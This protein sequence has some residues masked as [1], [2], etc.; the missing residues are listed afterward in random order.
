[1]FLKKTS[2]R[3][4]LKIAVFH[5]AFVYSGGGERIVIE[6]VLGLAAK[7]HK[8]DLF[9][10]AI[11][12]E[13]CYPELLKRVGPRS[14]I[15]QLPKGFPLRDGLSMLV[16]SLLV[17][18]LAPFFSGYDV[19]V[20]ANQPGS[21]LAF[22]LSKILRKP[23]IVYLNQPNRMIY[24]REIDRETGWTTNKSFLVLQKLIALFKPLV[25]WLDRLSI[26]KSNYLLA[27]GQYIG[28]I[29]SKIYGKDFVDCPAGANPFELTDIKLEEKT[30]YEGNFN[31]AGHELKK[32]YIL[33][34]N[35]HYPQKKFEYALEALRFV[36]K[37]CPEASLAISGAY[38]DY[39]DKLKK[40]VE[41]YHLE[42]NVTFLGEVKEKDLPVLY[43][44]AAVYVYTSPAEDYGMGVVEAQYAAVPV[45]AWNHAGPTVT[46][47]NGLTGFLIEPYDIKDYAKKIYYLLE[48]KESRLQMGRAAREHVLQKFTW[49]AHI[50]TL[51]G[52]IFKSLNI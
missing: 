14:L 15:P 43:Q 27:N 36:V 10:P 4:E 39:T 13:K 34:T 48:N 17:W 18:A 23:Y 32:P 51:E 30:Y 26:Q 5:C 21:W 35:R 41:N 20:G 19:F 52:S 46:V 12:E 9:A 47:K 37:E 3:R 2:K 28:E 50:D 40:L 29:I 38:T 33:L 49:R 11:D 7:G 24:P 8:V 42:K 16:N 25:G 45:V 1:M 44:N 6:E 31:L 22:V